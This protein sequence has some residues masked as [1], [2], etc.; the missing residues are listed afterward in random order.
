M[1]HACVG[2]LE[3]AVRLHDAVR[4]GQGMNSISQQEQLALEELRIVGENLKPNVIAMPV[5]ASLI[6]L[7]FWQ[8]MPHGYLFAWWGLVFVA[9]FPLHIVS[10]RFCRTEGPT[11]A[12]KWLAAFC[13]AIMVFQLA[14]GSMALLLWVRENDFDHILIMLVLGSTIAGNSV[15]AGASSPIT[16]TAFVVYG[17]AM[18]WIPLRSS[19]FV[20]DTLAIVALVYIVFLFYMARVYHGVARKMLVLREDK[21]NLVERLEYALSDATAAR[22][23]AENANRAK[24]QFLAGM[25]HELR[26]PLNAIIGFSE[27]ISLRVFE[28]NKERQIEYAKLVLGAGQHLLSLI[29]DVLD[30]AK[31]ESGRLELRECE[32]DLSSLIEESLSFIT[33]RA[34]GAGCALVREMSGDLPLI[35]GDERALKQVLLNLLSNAVKF[36]P[37]GGSITSFARLTAQGDFEFGVRDSGIGI[38][39][40]EIERVFEKFGQ[41][42]TD[43]LSGDKGTGLGLPIVKGLIELHG[44]SVGIESAPNRGTCVTVTLPGTRLRGRRRFKAQ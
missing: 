37:A 38:A 25:S 16:F 23:R 26:T 33:P 24:S 34:E 14:W 1:L 8:W 13:A 43:A 32:V 10:Q 39:A 17:P 40:E 36:T 19:G 31:I 21:R 4:S 9:V 2:V 20:Y 18:V 12:R 3:R 44:G 30:L 22:A 5:L 7:M 28:H 27:L 42:K 41:G 15:L 29:N 6:C 11:E 35:F